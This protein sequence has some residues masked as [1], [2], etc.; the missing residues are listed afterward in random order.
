MPTRTIRLDGPLDLGRTLAPLRR[1]RGDPTMRIGPDGVW[2]ATRTPDG[3]ATLHLAARDGAVDVEA[4]GDGAGWSLEHAGELIGLRD[5]P[6]AFQADHP[7]LRELAGRHPGLRF[8]RTLGVVEALIPAIVEQKVTGDEAHRAWR[9]LVA[10][11]G[12][13][14]PG[15]AGANGPAGAP[16]PMGA[17]G[18]NRH[19]ETAPGP[20]GADGS[21]GLRLPPA[22]EVLAALPYF[23][24]H[25]FGLER[26]RAETIRRVAAAAT[27]LEA[28]TE[29]PS[30]EGQ[31][32]LQAIPGIG[33]WT[34][35][36]VAARAWGDPDAVSVGD[37]HLPNL[38]AWA[39]AREPRGTDERMLE[40]LAPFAGQRGRVIRLLEVAGIAAPRHGPR[41]AGRRIES[42]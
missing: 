1:G 42:L 28:T 24:F 21:T 25:P 15:P 7:L 31:A 18:A 29:L 12:E 27:R 35:A 10:A 3:P 11:H 22:P 30:A 37:F 32:R 33:P 8:P 36:E 26:R 16:G 40:L 38:V 2:R 17:A 23:A 4:W 5:D 19:G 34:A 39:L 41:Y 14:A 6:A 9:G 20:A 13:P